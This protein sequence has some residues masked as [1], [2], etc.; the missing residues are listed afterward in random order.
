KEDEA[1]DI[2]EKLEAAGATVTLK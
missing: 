1:N 2:K